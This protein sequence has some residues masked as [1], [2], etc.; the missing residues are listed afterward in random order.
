M[1]K[2]WK[3]AG[4][5]AKPKPPDNAVRTVRP[6]DDWKAAFRQ[7]D[8]SLRPVRFAW[9]APGTIPDVPVRP[10]S[11]DHGQIVSQRRCV[12][13]TSAPTYHMPIAAESFNVA[14]APMLPRFLSRKVG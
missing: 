6:A 9:S 4:I 2:V 13:S 12:V 10:V 14:N 8:S 1:S 11:P 7:A 3:T 5:A